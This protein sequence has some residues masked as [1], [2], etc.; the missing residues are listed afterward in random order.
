MSL[1]EVSV[2]SKGS[3]DQ[4]FRRMRATLDHVAGWVALGS[5]AH[6]MHEPLSCLS[7]AFAPGVVQPASWPKG[8]PMTD[9]GLT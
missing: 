1:K 3:V 9:G 7:L 6:D 4:W 2:V 8:L 5:K